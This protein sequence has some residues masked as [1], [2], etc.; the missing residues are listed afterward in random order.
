MPDNFVFETE[1][2]DLLRRALEAFAAWAAE[3]WLMAKG[4]AETLTEPTEAP[5]V[6]ERG[7]NEA[8][9]SIPHAAELWMNEGQYE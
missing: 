8:I 7:Y 9:R 3:N 1:A 4:E 6:Y 5:A 2:S